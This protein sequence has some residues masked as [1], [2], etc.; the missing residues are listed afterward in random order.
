MNITFQQNFN[1]LEARLMGE[2]DHH[3]AR[4]IAETIDFKIRRLQP[5]LLILDFG[6]VSFMDSSGLAVVMG[7][8]R[9]MQSLG[10][11]IE[12]RHLSGSIQ[13]IFEMAELSRYVKI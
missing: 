1:E 9:L 12:L 13:K 2:I 11:Q 4:G 3:S 7:R 8:W 10:G 6:G 5:Q